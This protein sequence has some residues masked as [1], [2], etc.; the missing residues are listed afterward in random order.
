M[1]NVGFD[2]DGAPDPAEATDLVTFIQLLAR[3]RTWAGGPSL[4]TLAKQVGPLMRPPRPVSHSTVGEAFQTRRQ[5]LDLD[6]V[7]AI[8]R[9]LGADEATV[10]RWRAAYMRIQHE[11]GSGGVSGVYRQLPPDLATFT[12][13]QEPLKDLLWTA[14]AAQAEDRTATVVVSAVDGMAGIGKTQLVIHAAHELLRSGRYGDVQLY[15][16]LRGFDADQ[17][18]ADPAAVLSSFLQALEVPAQHIPSDTAARSAMFRDR[19]HGRH[20]L[21]VLDNAASAEQVRDLIPASPTCLVLITSR[22]TLSGLDGASWHPLDVFDRDE[23]LSLLRQIVGPTRVAAE[24]EAARRLVQACGHLPLAVALAAARLRSRPA[25]SVA[26][27]ADRLTASL[28][29]VAVAGRSLQA[30]FDLSYES[31]P[32]QARTVFRLLGEHPGAD[33]TAESVAVLADLSPACTDDV[34]EL[35]VD[36][37]LVQERSEDRYC[38]HD[39]LK[40]YSVERAHA[41]LDEADRLAATVRLLEWYGT[42]AGLALDLVKPARIRHPDWRAVPADLATGFDDAE[43]AG[44]WLG[45]NADTLRGAADLAERI[46]ATGPGW[47][48]WAAIIDI[49]ANRNPVAA[50]HLARRALATA[51]RAADPAVKAWLLFSIGGALGQQ[52]RFEAGIEAHEQAIELARQLGDRHTENL[53][54][55]WLSFQYSE[56]G[57]P[58]T[59]LGLAERAWDAARGLGARSESNALNAIATA[60]H[61]LGR[62][63]AALDY[64]RQIAGLAEDGGDLEYLAVARR[65]LGYTLMV[66]SRYAEAVPEFEQAIAHFEATGNTLRIAEC[67]LGAARAWELRSEAERARAARDSVTRWL[68]GLPAEQASGFRQMLEDSPLHFRDRQRA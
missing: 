45:R 30:V 20:A 52:R 14:A 50:E 67:R 35:L 10:G 27:L 34:L 3:L 63:L 61:A 41:E 8:V 23:A 13:R 11:A 15:V 17:P 68:N 5:R 47:Q 38:L 18:P 22:R 31:L 58:Q 60:L 62:P 19:M 49:E 55:S 7:L 1:G 59:G 21:V 25:W 6:L 39:L 36:E 57:R 16:N 54:L 48:L 33:F 32:D 26:R 42:R 24:P 29:E 51:A 64:I 37:H 43:A 9:A 56:S 2:S 44:I 66:L 4:R 65:N 28:D 12:G 53:Y 40:R 46:G